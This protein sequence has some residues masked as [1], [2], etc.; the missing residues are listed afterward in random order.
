MTSK[1]MAL[2]L[3]GLILGMIFGTLFSMLLGWI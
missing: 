3:S 1:S 2:G